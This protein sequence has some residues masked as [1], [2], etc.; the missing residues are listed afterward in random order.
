MRRLF[1]GVCLVAAYPLA[2]AI[3]DWKCVSDCTAQGYLYTVCVK[4]C[5]D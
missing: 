1:V 2:F 4:R 3:T 5:S